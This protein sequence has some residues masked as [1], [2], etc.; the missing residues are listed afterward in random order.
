M[1]SKGLFFYSGLT[2]DLTGQ[3]V[4]Q[5]VFLRCKKNK[6]TRS[7]GLTGETRIK[8]HTLGQS[9]YIHCHQNNTII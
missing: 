7:T 8:E 4:G 6:R 2:H 3:T 1:Q 9:Q 5:T